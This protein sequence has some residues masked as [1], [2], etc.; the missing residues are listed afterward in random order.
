MKGRERDGVRGNLSKIGQHILDC[1]VSSSISN[2]QLLDFRSSSDGQQQEP[3]AA[4]SGLPEDGRRG[5][6]GR[7]QEEEGVLRRIVAAPRDVGK[8]WRGELHRGMHRRALLLLALRA[9]LRLACCSKNQAKVADLL[10]ANAEAGV[11][12]RKPFIICLCV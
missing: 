3:L 5:A 11:I 4:S 1:L 12:R 10:C 2:S 9:L 8:A 7:R 6:A